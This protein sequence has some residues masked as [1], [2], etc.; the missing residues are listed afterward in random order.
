MS[1]NGGLRTHLQTTAV[2][3]E[4]HGDGPP[5]G[6]SRHPGLGVAAE[7]RGRH[8]RVVQEPQLVVVSRMGWEEVFLVWEADAN[9]H[10]AQDDSRRRVTLPVE[11]GGELAEAGE[12]VFGQPDVGLV[13]VAL[14]ADFVAFLDVGLV[15]LRELGPRDGLYFHVRNNSFFPG[16]IRVLF[17][18]HQVRHLFQPRPGI[19]TMHGGSVGMWCQYLFF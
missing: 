14:A 15:G 4:N 3:L 12:H 18:S 11:I 16:G 6:M 1:R 10:G 2:V 13:G 9:G 19:S 8:R 17:V 7:I 5:V